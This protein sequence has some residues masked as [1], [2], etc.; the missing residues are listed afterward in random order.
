MNYNKNIKIMLSIGVILSQ[1]WFNLYAIKSIKIEEEQT[2]SNYTLVNKN[3]IQKLLKLSKN[4]VEERIC[5]SKANLYDNDLTPVN[6]V[7]DKNGNILD[8]IYDNFLDT[9]P[10]KDAERLN[11]IAAKMIIYEML[12]NTNEELFNFIFQRDFINFETV[13]N[14]SE[15]LWEE[16]YVG[17][18]VCKQVEQDGVI[19]I[20]YSQNKEEKFGIKSLEE[21]KS[22]LEQLENLYLN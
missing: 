22:V 6:I 7:K 3:N 2:Q 13:E 9:S 18:V 12:R 5:L 17:V 19:P 1:F 10:E 16:E 20:L 11:L 14:N 4:I 15:K 8:V 21:L